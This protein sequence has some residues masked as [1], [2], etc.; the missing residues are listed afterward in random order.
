MLVSGQIWIAKLNT[1]NPPISRFST[2]EWIPLIDFG[3]NVLLTDVHYHYD[4]EDSFLHLSF[5]VGFVD[6]SCSYFKVAFPKNLSKEENQKFH[7]KAFEQYCASHFEWKPHDQKAVNV[8]FRENY[9]SS[10]ELIEETGRVFITTS[11]KGICKIWRFYEKKVTLLRVLETERYEIASSVFYKA[12]TSSHPGYYI[13]G[14]SRGGINIYL[15]TDFIGES[16]AEMRSEKPIYFFNKVHATDPVSKILGSPKG[17]ISIGHD[18]T[19]NYFEE[20]S[21]SSHI[22]WKVVNNAL[23]MPVHT[24]DQINI[25]YSDDTSNN[26]IASSS[27]YLSGFHGSSFLIY[28]LRRNYQLMRIEGGGWK[29]PHSSRLLL[30]NSQSK[31]NSSQLPTAL[32]TCPAP[33]GKTET[34]LQIIGSTIHANLESPSEYPIQLGCSS[35]GK[36]SYCSVMIEH[37]L[38][39][40]ASE[41]EMLSWLVVAGEDCT[42][43]VFSYPDLLLLQETTLS[44]NSSMKALATT[45]FKTENQSKGI[46][47]GGGGKLLYYIWLYDFEHYLDN[48]HQNNLKTMQSSFAPLQ[49]LYVGNIT[50][51]ASQDHRIMCVDVLFLNYFP[52]KSI[53]VASLPQESTTVNDLTYFQADVYECLLLLSDSR[54]FMTIVNFQYYDY[55]DDF[56]PFSSYERNWN[57]R[58]F[59]VVQHLLEI[60]SSPMLSCAFLELPYHTP[61]HQ[62]KEEDYRFVLVAGG[63]SRGIVDVLLLPIKQKT[64]VLDPATSST[65]NPYFR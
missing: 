20:F 55:Q 2:E 50:P 40:A 15:D 21:H 6:C 36:V 39:S 58:Q 38:C 26:P 53:P 60:S 3:K 37:E 49:K 47:V 42:M 46:V 10:L 14:D 28:D 32:F 48:P 33:V 18:S 43:K 13:I 59:S 41:K 29:R 4:T 9:T 24:C 63:D 30:P 31:S 35:F 23:T 17:F 27:I 7:E 62:E 16:E 34:E 52:Q 12:S 65:I 54:G 45:S 5:L 25:I 64:E 22:Y 51:D 11:L 57:K 44:K 61:E 8:W 19:I 1:A 56:L